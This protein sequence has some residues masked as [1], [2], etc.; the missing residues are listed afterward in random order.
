MDPGGVDGLSH[1]S[2]QGVYLSDQVALGESAYGR[3]AAHLR[4]GIQVSCQEKGSET[5]SCRGE[6][7][8]HSRVSG[9]NH[10]NIILTFHLQ[11]PA[12]LIYGDIHFPKLA[13]PSESFK[14][15]LVNESGKGSCFRHDK[16]TH[17]IMAT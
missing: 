13:S 2:A 5:H 12:V 10:N 6:R 17:H 3:I 4:D 16:K 11:F 9:S 1:L 15:A 7:G 8:L 14:A